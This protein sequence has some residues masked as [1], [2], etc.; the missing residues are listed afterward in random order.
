MAKKTQFN[1]AATC[2]GTMPHKDP[3]E[4]CKL[5]GK[6]LPGIPFWPQLPSRSAK[7]IMYLQYSEGFEGISNAGGKVSFTRP[8]NFDGQIEKLYTDY[9]EDNYRSYAV[10]PEYASGLYALEGIKAQSP[11]LIKGH[12]VGPISWGLSVVDES[13]R[14]ILYDEQLAEASAKFLHLKAAW[15]EHFLRKI[16]GNTI[17]FVD[18]PYM[19]SLGTAMVA[20]SDKQVSELLE[21][22][23]SGIKSIKGIHCCGATDWSLILKSSTDILSFDTYNYADSLATHV[24]DTEG[25]LA[26]G[27]SIAWGIIPNEEETLRRETVSSLF[28]RFGEAVA[29]FTRG[30][31]SFKQILAQSIITPS[32]GL[33]SLSKEAA[34]DVLVLLSELSA[35]LKA[36]Y[37]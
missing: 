28:D 36:K 23:L 8:E 26:G 35:K 11:G 14:G 30:G 37:L 7:E 9:A 13:G 24:K 4:A 3:V 18:E 16:A 32:C 33:A 20:I 5:I 22:V 21:E 29:P 25:F 27:G 34:E 10:T 17:I 15:Q 1:C 12:I 31:I 6:F 19:V 2:I